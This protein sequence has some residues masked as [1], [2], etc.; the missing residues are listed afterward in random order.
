MRTAYAQAPPSYDL[1]LEQGVQLFSD[2]K[3]AEAAVFF[4]NLSR[5]EPQRKDG[6]LWLGRTLIKTGDVG[7]AREAL[8][9]CYE[10]SPSDIDA[11]R[12]IA[13]TYEAEGNRELARLWYQRARDSNPN[14]K[15]T[16]DALE[17]LAS[18]D[19]PEPPPASSPTP[20]PT[21]TAANPEP[22]SSAPE[23]FWRTGL[24]GVTGART[25]W[26]G[27]V[28]ILMIFL[29]GMMQG[30]ANVPRL[31][32]TNP[33]MPGAA[34]FVPGLAGGAFWYVIFW[35]YPEGSEWGWFIGFLLL[36]SVGVV[37]ALRASPSY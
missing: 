33:A 23:G 11:P 14:D 28:L 36:Y 9:R 22:V 34:I 2:G 25:V 3:F 32:Q 29:G 8:R 27:R 7:R 20:A 35:G 30:V 16:N 19:S 10:L 12:E 24:A 17:R 6:F 15:A 21:P 1:R 13:R 37:S 31:R 18:T 4:A 26:W 5:V